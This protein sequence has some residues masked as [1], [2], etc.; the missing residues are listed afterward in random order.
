[1]FWVFV[2]YGFRVCPYK[3]LWFLVFRGKSGYEEI[4]RLLNLMQG[5]ESK[6]K[7]FAKP[8]NGSKQP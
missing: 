8:Q 3:E 6:L 4:S 2:M 7:L 5:R 1:M